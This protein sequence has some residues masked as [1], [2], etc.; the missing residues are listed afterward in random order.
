[1]STGRPRNNIKMV[2]DHKLYSFSNLYCY[3][4]VLV[5]MF[6]TP[7]TFIKF[8]SVL[9]VPVGPDPLFFFVWTCCFKS[10][11]PSLKHS[12]LR[13]VSSHSIEQEPPTENPSPISGFQAALAFGVT[14]A[15]VISHH[16]L[17][18]RHTFDHNVL[19]NQKLNNHQCSTVT[20]LLQWCHSCHTSAVLFNRK[21]S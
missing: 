4:K 21:I 2:K 10:C 15:S 3:L 16:Y 7:C 12:M 11:P 8:I 18:F 9:R 5:E 1:M 6:Y 13:L 14:S 17:H 20:N 19:L